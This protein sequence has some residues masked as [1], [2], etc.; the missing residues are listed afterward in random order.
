M[1]SVTRWSCTGWGCVGSEADDLGLRRICGCTGSGV[2]RVLGLRGIWAWIWGCAGSGAARDLRLRGIWDTWD[3]CL[4]R[5]Q[6]GEFLCCIPGVAVKFMTVFSYV[7]EFRG[8]VLPSK[9][10]LYY[11]TRLCWQAMTPSGPSCESTI[12]SSDWLSWLGPI[13]NH[14]SNTQ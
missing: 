13:F 3:V 12:I 14:C 1:A 2:A 7:V 10:K 5:A 11:A 6:R 9:L 4:S 8:P